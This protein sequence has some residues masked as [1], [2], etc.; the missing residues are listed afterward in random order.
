MAI[1]LSEAIRQGA[2][3]RPQTKGS[4]FT[5][6]DNPDSES[7][8]AI[9]CSCALGAAYETI[10]GDTLPYM[11]SS[12][13]DKDLIANTIEAQTSISFTKQVFPPHLAYGTS[14]FSAIC[15]LNDRQDW[16]RERIADWLEGI[17]L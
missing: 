5:I 1:K 8:E 13:I 10:T 12:T 4:Y 15:D 3:L 7:E 2:Q 9:V 6:A 14:L 11:P 17:G 16:S